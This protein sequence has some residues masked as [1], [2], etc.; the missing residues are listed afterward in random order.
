MATTPIL[1]AE[2]E[3]PIAE[4]VAELVADLG[5]TP[6]V[7]SDGRHALELARAQRPVLLVTDLM[8][9]HMSGAELIS[10]LRA[11]GDSAIPTILMTAAGS[12]A[13]RTAGADAVVPKPFDLDD[14]EAA[15]KRLLEQRA[16]H[17]P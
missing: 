3:P 11:G 14:M 16:Q 5:Y 13:A 6:L 12:Q 2:D 15:M 10:A 7:A 1:I 17:G 9:P 8:M 4:V